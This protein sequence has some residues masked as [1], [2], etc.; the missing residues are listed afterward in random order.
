MIY[1]TLGQE[2]RLRFWEEDEEES[3]PSPLDL[4][5]PITRVWLITRHWADLMHPVDAFEWIPEE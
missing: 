4:A 2:G 3:E 1:V 5:E